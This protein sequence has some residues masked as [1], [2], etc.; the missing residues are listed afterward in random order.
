MVPAQPHAIG[1]CLQ[2]KIRSRRAIVGV[3]GMGY[4]GLP[5]ALALVAQGFS[6]YGVD[7]DLQR[8]QA[9]R[10]GESYIMDISNDELGDARQ[11]GLFH[12]TTDY[13]VLDLCDGVI[14]C[15]PT[16]LRKT[17]EP[18]MSYILAAVAGLEQHL[19]SGMLIILESTTYPGTTDELLAGAVKQAG[20]QPGQD[21]FICF[22]PERVDPGNDRYK[23][24]N[25]PKVIGGVTPACT[26]MGV[27]L[28]SMTMKTV[29]PVSSARVAEM[30]K[31]LENTFRN[32]NI[33]FINEVALMCEKM[34]IDVWE[35]IGAA[36]S[37][38][39]GFVPFYPGPGIGG[40]CIPLDPLYLS[41]KARMY[42]FNNHFIELANDINT[43]M[44]HHVVTL[45][46][47]ALNLD[48]KNPHNAKILLLGM[49]YKRDVNDMRESP[50]VE[51]YEMLL[52]LGASVDVHDPLISQFQHETGTV[53]SI[54]LTPKRTAGYDCVVLLVD[55]KA[56]DYHALATHA[57]LIVDTR[58]GFAEIK[59]PHIIRL[60]APF[61][62]ISDWQTVRQRR[63]LRQADASRSMTKEG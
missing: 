44:P 14:I 29:V 19:H 42:K 40:H 51:I 43:S 5:L 2:D 20:Y 28:Y 1:E 56:Y 18:D 60:G 8:I 39:F 52:A 9:L 62:S 47:N 25:I 32:V 63:P 55:H 54:D 24:A 53:T 48:S 21:V 34:G 10:R 36:R 3:I 41:W 7:V 49:T 16:P 38:P 15:V 45:I 4:V 33:A 58:N 11:T 57:Q 12:P 6:T 50:S 59:E 31:L 26:D 61:P 17:Y 37:K 23:T 35:V 22:S 13:H 30:A 27:L 46:A